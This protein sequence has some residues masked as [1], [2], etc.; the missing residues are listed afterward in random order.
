MDKAELRATLEQLHQNLGDI[1][2][3]DDETRQL[4]V[5]LTADLHRLL[6]H[7]GDLSSAE[8]APLSEQLRSL[9]LRFETD[10][11]Q[12]TGLMGRMADSLANLGI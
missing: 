11:P 6:Q 5:T 1:E 7:S 9:V 2:P 4:V 12:L 3:I 8:T 10:H